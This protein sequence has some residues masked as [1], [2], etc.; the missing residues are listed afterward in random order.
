MLVIPV[1]LCRAN[2]KP[3]VEAE[4]KAAGASP[5]DIP[6]VRRISGPQL[7]K[8]TEA[9]SV[10]SDEDIDTPPGPVSPRPADL[11]PT[12]AASTSAPAA[13]PTPG[14]HRHHYHRCPIGDL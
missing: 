8:I 3:G 4:A 9:P 10:P 12:E 11:E 7:E 1:V 2:G 5:E 14:G 6:A 13:I